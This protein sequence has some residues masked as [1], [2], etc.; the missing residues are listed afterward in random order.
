MRTGE[1]RGIEEAVRID[2]RSKNLMKD[3]TGEAAR[4]DA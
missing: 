4:I 2:E 1:A 3:R